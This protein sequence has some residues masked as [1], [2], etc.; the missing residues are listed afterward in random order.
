M[1]KSKTIQNPDDSVTI[2]VT[3][4]RGKRDEWKRK[5]IGRNFKKLAEAMKY[6]MEI[7][8]IEEDTRLGDQP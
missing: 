3:V 1:A 4:T 5:A 8:N 7:W 2:T 6:R